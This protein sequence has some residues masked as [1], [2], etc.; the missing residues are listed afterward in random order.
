[1]GIIVAEFWKNDVINVKSLAD[2]FVAVMFV[3]ERGMFCYD[4]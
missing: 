2:R 4:Y 3:V 1:M